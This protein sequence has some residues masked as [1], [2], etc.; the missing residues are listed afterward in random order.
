MLVLPWTGEDIARLA[1]TSHLVPGEEVC[2][3]VTNKKSTYVECGSGELEQALQYILSSYNERCDPDQKLDVVF[4][5]KFIDHL[6]K[7]CRL[8]VGVAG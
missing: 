8:L 1:F 6:V 5:P 2:R 7:Q 4:F 3:N